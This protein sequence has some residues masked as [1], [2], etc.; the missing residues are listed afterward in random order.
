MG[1]D[2]YFAEGKRDDWRYDQ[3]K[4]AFEEALVVRD[5]QSDAWRE[6]LTINKRDYEAYEK[7]FDAWPPQAAVNEA[8]REMI[9]WGGD[10]RLNIWGMGKWREVAFEHGYLNTSAV[11]PKGW[12]DLRSY[13]WFME[14]L[15][16]DADDKAVTLAER[17][18]EI[19]KRKLT[20]IQP[21]PLSGIP[22]YKLGSNDGWL[23]TVDECKWVSDR[24]RLDNNVSFG[25]DYLDRFMVYIHDAQYYGGFRVF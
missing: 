4:K 12:D 10:F 15:P 1:Y 21:S 8:L 18:Y 9:Y 14:Q 6:T 25:E 5:A 7:L 22:A 24:H 23:V 11:E 2:M 13:D 17:K 20:D 16:E 19:E 3:A